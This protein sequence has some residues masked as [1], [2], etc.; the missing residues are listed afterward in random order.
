MDPASCWNCAFILNPKK[1]RELGVIPTE[2]ELAGVGPAKKQQ[3]A[4]RG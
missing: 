4:A 1:A 2:A 3:P